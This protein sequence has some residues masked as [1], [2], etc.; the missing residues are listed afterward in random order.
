MKVEVI[1]R[2][3][4]EE[5]EYREAMRIVIN[6]KEEFWFGDGEPEDNTL[7]RNFNDIYKIPKMLEMAF[8]AGRFGELFSISET[9]SKDL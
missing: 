6:D 1:R 5:C 9:K 4:V 3:E 8:N 2:S 7:G